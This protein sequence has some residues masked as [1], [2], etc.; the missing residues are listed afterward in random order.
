MD[1]KNVMLVSKKDGQSYI[2]RPYTSVYNIEGLDEYIKRK[3]TQEVKK[4]IE[5]LNLGA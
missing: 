4:Q 2:I 3:V 5:A 1:E